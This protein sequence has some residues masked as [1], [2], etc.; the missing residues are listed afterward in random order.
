MRK[1]SF[2]SLVTGIPAAIMLLADLPAN[3]QD[4]SVSIVGQ[5]QR[6]R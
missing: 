2:L 3:S 6:D 4:F 5:Q 1:L